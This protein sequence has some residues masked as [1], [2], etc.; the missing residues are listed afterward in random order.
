MAL[1]VPTAPPAS[2]RSRT[3]NISKGLTE[4]AV[5]EYRSIC[6]RALHAS[7]D[8]IRN[9]SLIRNPLPGKTSAESAREVRGGQERTLLESFD[10]LDAT[11]RDELAFCAWSIS[12]YDLGAEW[13]VRSERNG[14]GPAS[15]RPGRTACAGAGRR[16][17]GGGR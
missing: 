17:V 12:K 10:R 7:C 2:A 1:T 3:V 16:R 5:W 8:L 11:L 14:C 9:C 15:M 6:V 4:Q 13:L